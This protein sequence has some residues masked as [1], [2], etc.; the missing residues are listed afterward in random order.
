MIKNILVT[1]GTGYIGSHLCIKL[2]QKG[3]TVTVI[4]NLINSKKEIINK[5][6]F[7]KQKNSFIIWKFF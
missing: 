6:K 4:D 5:I 3:Y 2:L 7:S 1:G